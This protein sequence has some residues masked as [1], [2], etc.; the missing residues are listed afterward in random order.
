M[1]QDEPISDRE[2][3]VEVIETVE[4]MQKRAD[5]LRNEGAT[6]G[7]VP[8][9]GFFHEGHLELMRVGKRHSDH[10][11]V[12]IFVNPTQFGPNED[13]EEYPRDT[14]GDLAKARDVGVDTVFLPSVEQMYPEGYQTRVGLGDLTQH[15]CGLSRPGHFDGVATVVAKL[16][17]IVKPHLAL[18]GQK[19]YQQLTVISRMVMDLNMDIDIVGVPTVREPDGLAMSSRNNYLSAEERK[20][21]LCLKE[22]LE[23]ADQLV[24]RGETDPRVVLEAVES[25]IRRYPFTEI[26]YVALCDPVTLRDIS[27]LGEEQLLALA[28]RVG[29]TRL[30]DNG[31]LR[32]P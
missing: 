30:I 24:R 4:G 29:K 28:V 2:S 16:F 18:F 9:M 11:A 17:H 27:T 5:L 22:S 19:D 1:P 25:L 10:L 14:E 7:L 6:I 31:L 23:L 15:L 13:F 26:D 20:S 3:T 8:T 12:S 32:R 21:A